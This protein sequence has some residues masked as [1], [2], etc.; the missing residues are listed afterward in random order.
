MNKVMSAPLGVGIIGCGNIASTYLRLAPLFKTI[1]LR[2]VADLNPAAAKAQ[3]EAF[4]VPAMDVDALL[5]NDD[6]D[7]IVNLTVP[8]AHAA[9]TRSI[10]EA[11]KHAYSE[12]PMVLSLEEGE[13]IGTLAASKSLRVSSAP[14]TFLGGAHQTARMAIDAGD[15]GSITSGTC[16]LMSHGMEH[17]HPN[18][19][20]F[21]QPGAGP[22]FDMGP[23]YITNLLQLLGPVRQVAALASSAHKE[24][25]ITSQPRAGEKVPVGTPTDIHA[26]LEF[27]QGATITLSTSWDVW[28]HRHAPME[29]YGTQGSLYLP[30]PNFFGGTLERV[31]PTGAIQALTTDGH[32]LGLANERLDTDPRANYRAAGLAD[33]AAAIQDNRPH[34][35]S[36]EMALHAVDVMSS[37]LKSG[38]TNAFVATSTTFKRPEPLMADQAAALM[39]Q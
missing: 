13:Q 36:F 19:D 6:I 9:V 22:M 14:D 30:D 2:G 33:M 28:A 12:K 25:A 7:I 37:I 32:P 38:Q 15:V 11:G 5:A 35:C 39:R 17:W 24:R 26:L 4:G 21:Y 27:D 18:P 1:E 20:F 16:H 10:L 23:Y 8:T 29:L 3:S 31:D 34:R